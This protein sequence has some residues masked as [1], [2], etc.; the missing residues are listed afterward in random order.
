MIITQFRGIVA[1]ARVVGESLA[2]DAI[3]E[4]DAF[5]WTS[6]TFRASVSCE[7]LIANALAAVTLSVPIANSSV[8]GSTPLVRGST[9]AVGAG[10]AMSAF[11]LPTLA[12]A[13]VFAPA[14]LVVVTIAGEVITFTEAPRDQLGERVPY[15]ATAFST[16]T[17]STTGAESAVTRRPAG[18]LA[19][20]R[21]GRVLAL[22]MFPTV[23]IVA[24]TDSALISTDAVAFRGFEIPGNFLTGAGADH[25]EIDDEFFAEADW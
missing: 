24:L 14:E 18:F 21:I 9:A 12:D 13:A 15:V 19:N 23:A 17:F 2:L 8:G 4:F 10:P 7:V 1:T 25:F 6:G 5:A 11:T 22:A 20:L 3:L 16:M